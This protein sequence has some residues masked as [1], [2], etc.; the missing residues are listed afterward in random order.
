MRSCRV[1]R[2]S[3]RTRSAFSRSAIFR[4][5][6]DTGIPSRAAALEKLPASTTRTKRAIAFLSVAVL[7]LCDAGRL[8]V[9]LDEA[10]GFL[11]QPL[12]CHHAGSEHVVMCKLVRREPHFFRDVFVPGDASL[13][14]LVKLVAYRPALLLIASERRRD[15]RPLGRERAPERNRILHCEPG[16][17]ADRRMRGALRIA[18][19]HD[20][21]VMPAAVL[22]QAPAPPERAVADQFL[23]AQDACED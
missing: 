8:G 3:K 6:V 2:S 11:R 21:Q 22:D 12:G 18:D 10:G 13:S 5:T 9:A 23:S 20:V 1:E 7:H 19:E 15:V 16:P 14:R 4:L 17:R